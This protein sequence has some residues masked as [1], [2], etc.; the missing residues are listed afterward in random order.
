V[1]WYQT[2]IDDP[3][4]TLWAV[5]EN[6]RYLTKLRFAAEQVRALGA[7]RHF[8]VNVHSLVKPDNKYYCMSDESFLPYPER[9]I[10]TTK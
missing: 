6:W 8:R 5:G 9:R 2:T 3:G 10:V 7:V 1:R 4:K